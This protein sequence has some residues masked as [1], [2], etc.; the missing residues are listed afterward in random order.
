MSTPY[1]ACYYSHELRRRASGEDVDKLSKS[2]FDASV[3]LTPHQVEAALFVFRSPLSKGVILADEVGLGKTIEAGLVLCQLWAERKRRLLVI[4]PASLRKQW[5]ME[6]EEKFNLPT[7]I[8]ESR[9][10]N[11]AIK[12]GFDNPFDTNAVVITS[13]NFASRMKIDIKSITWDSVVIDEAHKLRNAYR[14]SNRMG[15]AIK[16][17]IEDR[18]KVLLTATPLQNSLLEL[19]G[20]SSIIDDYIFG[21]IKSFRSQFINDGE[22][23]EL[24]QRLSMFCQRTL[25]SQVL[26]YVKFTERRAITRP[27]RPSDQEQK[28]YESIAAFLQRDGNYAIPA[29]QRTLTTLILWKLL[30]SSSHAIAGTF[31]TMKERLIK[32]RDG[33]EV[34][35]DII[36]DIIDQEEMETDLIEDDSDQEY[37]EENNNDNIADINAD[38]INL[39]KLNKEIQEL[40]E[41]ILQAEHIGIDSKSNA[42][43][44]ALEIGMDE[45]ERMGANRKALIFT[46]SRRTQEYLFQFLEANGYQGKVMLFNG[47]NNDSNSKAIYDQ[48]LQAFHGTDRISGARTADKRAA[49]LEFFKDHADIMIATESAA[50]GINMQFC[51]LVIN[52]DLPWNPQRI[53]QRIGRCHRYGQKYD[54]VVINF[55]N[56]RN[57]ADL[58]V[59]E[60][61]QEK[62]NLFNGVFGAS[63]EVLGTIE[64]GVDFEKKILSIYQQCRSIEEIEVAF[65]SL[66]QE[67]EEIINS[68]ME[69]TRRVLLEN[70]DEDVHQRLNIQL[71]KTQY[72]LDRVGNQFWELTR[73]ILTD[74]AEFNEEDL[75]FDLIKSPEEGIHPGRY[76]MIAKGRQPDPM[77]NLYR[78]AHPL[79]EY[80]LNQGIQQATPPAE[81]V[82]DISNHPTKISVIE[83]LKGKSGYLVLSKLS[84]ESLEQE[85]HLL[86]NAYTDDGQLLD[87][88]CCE[89]LF[90]CRGKIMHILKIPEQQIK[91]LNME[92]KR[93]AEG[94]FNRSM[95][96]NNRYF[97]QERDRLEKWADDMVLGAEKD[98]KDTRAKIKIMNRQ[99][100][101]ATNMQEQLDCEKKLQELNRL[102][103]KQRQQIFDLED[104]ILEKRDHLIKEIEQKLISKTNHEVLFLLRFHVA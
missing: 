38:V 68:R 46:E 88:E 53:E 63:D 80:V 15:Q 9:T 78:L 49:L 32:L 37:V 61:L 85:D 73:F 90:K 26:Q 19:Y 2:L 27:F 7:L 75:C 20:L 79:G 5:S 95:E 13:M 65:N 54:V 29:R 57:R 104:Q 74:Y 71:D 67:M 102:L 89:R 93:H 44:T 40:N 42:L 86:F 30:A 99:A 100:R 60:L 98:L 24:R 48:W 56:D 43:L 94:R 51:S 69:D 97:K 55:L 52:Y 76:V 83:E 17:A 39:E 6:L 50:E 33:L 11:Q 35:D 58:R 10:Y 66:Q 84:I 101:N 47:S 92:A 70:F 36:E 14:P 96:S 28:F 22:I 34:S 25:R 16:W 45:M 21:D 81:V 64:S 18:K 59:Y 87:Q 62:F 72:C 4:C 12:A 77:W 23:G 31:M 41:F 8:L 91:R 1:H 82:F 3:D 103:R